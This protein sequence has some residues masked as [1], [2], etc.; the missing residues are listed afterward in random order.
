MKTLITSFFLVALFSSAAQADQACTEQELARQCKTVDLNS[1]GFFKNE[2]PYYVCQCP[3]P[4]RECI[5]FYNR[6]TEKFEVRC[7]TR[8]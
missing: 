2:G 1:G 6:Q 7:G 5:T 3:P 4:K 8:R